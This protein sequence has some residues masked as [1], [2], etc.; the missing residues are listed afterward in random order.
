[1]HSAHTRPT[2]PT[3]SHNAIGSEDPYFNAQMARAMVQGI[4][5]NNSASLRPSCARRATRLRLLTPR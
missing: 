3:P 4:Q 1:M 2:N 5:S